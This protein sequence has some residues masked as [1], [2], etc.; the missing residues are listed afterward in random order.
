V[1]RLVMMMSR[2]AVM[3][4]GIMVVLTRGM[5]V[6]VGHNRSPGWI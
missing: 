4:G 2:S 5:F 3:S 6:L 1:R